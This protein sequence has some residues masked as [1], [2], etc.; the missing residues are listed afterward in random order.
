MQIV[1]QVMKSFEK[2]VRV[3]FAFEMPIKLQ[4][5]FRKRR[6]IGTWSVIR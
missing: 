4:K 3:K 1:I 6:D 2:K 5:D